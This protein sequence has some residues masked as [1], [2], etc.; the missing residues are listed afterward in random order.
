MR[1]EYFYRDEFRTDDNLRVHVV[2][3]AD[4]IY[5]QWDFNAGKVS[6][7]YNAYVP[8]GVGADGR[9]DEVFGN[10]HLHSGP[11]ALHLKDGDPVPV[12]V[13]LQL[14]HDA[15]ANLLARRGIRRGHVWC[16]WRCGQMVERELKNG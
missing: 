2:P 12:V 11:D 15:R 1:T 8:N 16:D 14:S 13:A 6:K 3:P 9:N 10:M 4:G 7:Y 5:S